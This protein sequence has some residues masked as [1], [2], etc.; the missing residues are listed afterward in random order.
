MNDAQRDSCFQKMRGVAV[1]E[2]VDR[3]SLAEVKLLGD[4][5]DR[6]LYGRNRHHGRLIMADPVIASFGGEQEPRMAMR[7]PVIMKPV[8]CAGGKWHVAILGAF[9]A[10]NVHPTSIGVDISDLEM[11]SFLQ[12]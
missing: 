8:Q 6:S 5:L 10:M 11:E 2:R 7:L 1:S 12:S 4:L 9:A 3:D